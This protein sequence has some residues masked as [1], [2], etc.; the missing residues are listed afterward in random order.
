MFESLY[1]TNAELMADIADN[2]FSTGELKKHDQ[3]MLMIKN[4]FLMSV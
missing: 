1:A 4:E 3:L 2:P